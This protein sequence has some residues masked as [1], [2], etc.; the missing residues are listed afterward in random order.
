MTLASSVH[1]SEAVASTVAANEAAPPVR[2]ALVL[3]A[4]VLVSG[5]AAAITHF[6]D[7]VI[8]QRNIALQEYGAPAALG[9]F[10]ALAGLSAACGS[11]GF[12]GALRRGELAVTLALVLAA[13]PLVRFTAHGLV[14]TVGLTPA[15]VD[16]RHPSL[17]ALQ[18]SN[19]FAAL[20]ERQYLP[21][22]ES[23]RFEAVYDPAHPGLAPVAELPWSV[24][25]GPLV[26]WTPLLLCYIALSVSLGYVLHRQWSRHE[27]LQFPLAQYAILLT[28]TGPG[29]SAPDVCYHRSFWA[30]VLAML[31][32]FSARGIQSHYE[33]MIVLP[34]K[35]SYY[36]LV[37]QFPFLNYSLEGY[38]L[39][40]GTV[41]FSI[42][43]IA[44][45]LPAELSFT[46]WA[47]WPAMIAA[48]F[49][50]YTQTGERFTSQDATM[51]TAGAWWGMAALILWTGRH[52]YLGLLRAAVTGSSPRLAGDDGPLVWL[53]RVLILAMFGLVLGL[54]SVG[55]PLDLAALWT[56]S[57]MVST[58]VLCRLVGEMGLPWVP[59][60]AAGPV[61]LLPKALGEAV[62]GAR[63][64]SISA[65]VGGVLTPYS[66]TMLPLAPG[67]CNAA[68]VHGP[69]ARVGRMAAL[70]GGFCC[71]VLAASVVVLIVLGYTYEGVANDLPRFT[72]VIAAANASAR[73]G[74]DLQ[75]PLS[76][77][78]RWSGFS[79]APGFLLW[80][81]VG[82]GLVLVMGGLRLRFARFPFHP[83]PVVLFGSWL[84]SRFWLAFLIGWFI[85]AAVI[86][87]GG[88]NLFEK[89]RPFFAGIVA[90][91]AFTLVVW[92]FA[93]IALFVAGGGVFDPT[94]WGFL[95][96]M[97]SS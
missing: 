7:G 67:V 34:T 39:L 29:R 41:Y 90:G 16:A 66:N 96:D 63:G 80:S 33:R 15:L 4:A 38:S 27:L 10:A 68:Q 49:L 77:A 54:W 74:G 47:L 42:V 76:F 23:A 40:R 32:I 61:A 24:W 37:S 79:P 89:C 82:L 78:E 26:R 70:V 44:F 72:D 1:E 97:Y 94:W 3:A 52:Y 65:V 85:K 5:A 69:V 22:Q 11:V 51:L 2:W 12:R 57:L 88:V 55:M 60:A 87:I 19:P 48:T 84:L 83:L 58:I 46:A 53:A 75:Q 31:A 13:M 91:L 17:V 36:D 9:L 92:M 45:L 62:L 20:D 25:S 21:L 95:S 18:K 86:K 6:H 30:G 43:A 14:T 93:H 28:R 56:L 50:Y 64:L 71:F 35:F 8:L 59:L 73:L 81:A